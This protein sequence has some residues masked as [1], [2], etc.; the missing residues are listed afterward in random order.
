MSGIVADMSAAKHESADAR[1]EANKQ[2]LETLLGLLRTCK[3]TAKLLNVRDHVSMGELLDALTL[4]EL[5]ALR[6]LADD[7]SEHFT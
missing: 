6:V 3:E 5:N 2:A 4:S 7:A 1:T